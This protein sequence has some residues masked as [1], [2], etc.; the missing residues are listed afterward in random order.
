[1]KFDAKLET[2]LGDANKDM[3]D[4]ATEIW[5]GIQAVATVLD[6]T[7]DVHL[8]LA[9]F[10]LD[11]LLVISLGLSFCQD[12]PFQFDAADP[13]PLPSRTGPA[14]PTL[15]LWH[16]MIRGTLSQT[17]RPPYPSSSGAG[18]TKVPPEGTKQE[19]PGR[20]WEACSSDYRGL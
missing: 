5:T 15:F 4:K 19:F 12:I 6:M 20:T 11:R 14:P 3:T 2:Y 8:G 1:M 13:R 10:L 7:P 17:P 16:Q 18:Y 9:L